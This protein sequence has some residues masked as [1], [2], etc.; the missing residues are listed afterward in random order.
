MFLFERKMSQS[1][2]YVD[3]CGLSSMQHNM[4]DIQDIMAVT[5]IWRRAR[6]SKDGW[7]WSL[8]STGGTFSRAWWKTNI[9]IICSIHPVY[10]VKDHEIIEK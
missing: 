6:K 3:K 10:I 2:L 4:Q 1:H 5:M 9:S 8:P 7:A